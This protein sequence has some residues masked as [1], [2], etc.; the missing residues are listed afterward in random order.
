LA[1]SKEAQLPVLQDKKPNEVPS[2]MYN[3]PYTFVPA[4]ERWENS[5]A[6]KMDMSNGL[7]AAVMLAAGVV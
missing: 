5:R 6:N 4:G 3:T 7:I 1:A 2:S